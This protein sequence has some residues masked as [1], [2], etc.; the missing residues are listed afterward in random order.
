MRR[1]YLS[2]LVTVFGSLILIGWGL[3]IVAEKELKN[4]SPS[5]LELYQRIIHSAAMQLDDLPLYQLDQGIS[6]IQ[7]QFKLEFFVE[8]LANLALPEELSE[9]LET[10]RR[11]S[12]E[13]SE[14]AFLIEKLETHS[15]YLLQLS[16]P[17][18]TTETGYLDIALTLALYLGVGLALAIWLLPLTSRLSLL[19]KTAASFGTGKLDERV[20][21]SRFSYISNLE[22]S[23]NRMAAQIET[24]VADNKFLA[25][26]LSH[27][28]RT[29]VACLR[30]GV[31][32]ALDTQDEK[33]RL[34]YL[35]RIDEELTRME[36]MLEAFLSY[37]SMERKAQELKLANTD[38]GKL[39]YSTVEEMQALAIKGNIHLEYRR[40]SSQVFANVDYQW[41]YRALLNLIS[42]AIDHANGKVLACLTTSA[43]GLLIEIHDD[44][45]GVPEEKREAIFSPFVTVEKSRNR[46]TTSYGLGLAIVSRVMHWHGGQIT[47]TNSKPLNGACFSILISPTLS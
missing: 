37:A 3:D 40:P 35:Q 45:Q 19:T 22:S 16:V 18:S 12:L 36:D 11:L 21:P 4:T 41:F 20:K 47:I 34:Q 2:I 17:L 27:D 46:Q 32:A 29:P 23:F 1:V 33:K 25:Q 31:E 5:E 24:L 8:P 42:N 38:I 43:K 26:S 15:D 10:N 13:S 9:E 14:G 28:L 44:G 39:V 30:F 7:E 6:R